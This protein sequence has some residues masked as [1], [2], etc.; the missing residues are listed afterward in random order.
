MKINLIEFLGKH[1]ADSYCLLKFSVA[2]LYCVHVRKLE[3]VSIKKIQFSEWF[4]SCEEELD[5]LCVPYRHWRTR[6]AMRVKRHI[7][8]PFAISFPFTMLSL[9][10]FSTSD[11]LIRFDNCWILITFLF[12]IF[13]FFWD[14]MWVALSENLIRD[15]FFCETLRRGLKLKKK[16]I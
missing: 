2:F 9:M 16:E 13:F 4:I 7:L 12:L 14:V 10:G 6:V 8:L 1:F 11:F 3:N 5:E 15:V